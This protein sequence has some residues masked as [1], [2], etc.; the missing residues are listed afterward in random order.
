[1]AHLVSKKAEPM[2]VEVASN[3]SENQVAQHDGDYSGAIAK[4][5]AVE[6][7]L[8]RKLDRRVLPILWAMYFL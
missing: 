5:D 6:I 1:M 8:V 4:T 7:A 3:N 2:Q